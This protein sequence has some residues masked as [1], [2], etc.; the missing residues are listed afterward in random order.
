[1]PSVLSLNDQLTA[2]EM[3]KR[4][5]DKQAAFIIES[6]SA[7]NQFYLDAV[8][9]QASDGTVNRTTVRATLPVGTRRIYNKPIRSEASQTR[10]IEDGIEMLEAYS[11][12]D[13]DLA[14]QSP[15]R[16]RAIST[17]D[18][19]FLEGMGQTQV[20]DLLYARRYDGPEFID[21]AYARLPNI[22]DHQSVFS[23]GDSGTNLAS[24]LLIKWAEDKAKFIYPR[25]STS[26][27]VS[28]EWR[29]KQDVQ[30]LDSEGNLGTLPMYRTFYKAHFG[31]S[32]RDWRAIKR[33]CNIDPLNDSVDYAKSIYRQ[34]IAA[35][36]KL[37][38]GNGTIVAYMNSDV[39]TLLEQYM[40]IERTLY[41]ATK[42]DPWGRP[43]LYMN[44]MRFRQLDGMLSTEALVPAA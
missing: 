8:T 6:L 36:N 21:G 1:M 10:Q 33:V 7:T 43:T 15:D 5:G 41:T 3:A 12:V 14:D 32:I 27:G 26:I 4:F 34:L 28:A 18:T 9:G 31:L 17:E 30:V 40:V 13:A 24:I 29:G 22:V 25:G 44:D 35:K 39:L 20:K 19:A 37:P 38:K 23:V 42:D 2:L 16:K 11:D